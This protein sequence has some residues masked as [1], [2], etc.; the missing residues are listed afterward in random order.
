M[1]ASKNTTPAEETPVTGAPVP[2][3]ADDLPPAGP[4]QTIVK[5]PTGT[6]SVVLD[7]QVESLKLQGYTVG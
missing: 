4:G 2:V 5:S 3:V 6:R 7:Y 1:P